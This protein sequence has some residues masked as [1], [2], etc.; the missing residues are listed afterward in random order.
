MEARLT[1]LLS[2]SSGR[3]LWPQ[4]CLK[5]PRVPAASPKVWAHVLWESR[6]QSPSL[7]VGGT[8]PQKGRQVLGDQT[9]GSCLFICQ[10][11]L[12]APSQVGS[13]GI[14]HSYKSAALSTYPHNEQPLQT[15]SVMVVFMTCVLLEGI[16]NVAEGRMGADTGGHFP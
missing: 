3:G 9:H 8:P 14:T 15:P 11:R 5:G 4:P 12:Y 13:K 1:W 6:D 10:S 16:P 7:I 2:G